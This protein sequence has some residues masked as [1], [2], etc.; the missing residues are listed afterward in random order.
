MVSKPRDC[1]CVYVL[2]DAG[3]TM[4]LSTYSNVGGV[5]RRPTRPVLFVHRQPEIQ[6]VARNWADTITTPHLRVPVFIGLIIFLFTISSG[7]A[8]VLTVAVLI[9]LLYV[10]LTTVSFSSPT[11]F[12]HISPQCRTYG[13]PHHVFCRI[14][15]PS[16]GCGAVSQL[17]GIR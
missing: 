4:D 7:I 11:K 15:W 5:D 16:Y 6:I 3:A 2:Y 17:F 12:A 9:G 10:I 13:S 8:I 1:H 14:V